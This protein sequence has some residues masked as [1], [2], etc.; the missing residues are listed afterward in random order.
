MGLLPR[1]V[2]RDEKVPWRVSTNLWSRVRLS[3]TASNKITAKLFFHSIT[4]NS[5]N[6]IITITMILAVGSSDANS[7]SNLYRD[8]YD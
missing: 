3:A 6:N 7:D 1:N 2:E 8:D 5:N 4:N